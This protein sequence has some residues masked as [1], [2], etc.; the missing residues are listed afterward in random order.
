[1]KIRS[2][3]IAATVKKPVNPSHGAWTLFLP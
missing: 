2:E 3:S 1:M